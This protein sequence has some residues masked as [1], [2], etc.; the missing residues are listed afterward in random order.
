MQS[1]GSH[2]YDQNW[3]VPSRNNTSDTTASRARHWLRRFFET[4]LR[5]ER[6]TYAPS[7]Y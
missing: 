4:G 3:Q 5:R 2:A 6:F 7:K 1:L